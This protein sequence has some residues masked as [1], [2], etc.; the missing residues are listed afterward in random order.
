MDLY[1]T[2]E[3]MR[4]VRYNVLFADMKLTCWFTG[5]YLAKIPACTRQKPSKSAN[6][7]EIVVV[8]IWQTG[9]ID[10]L[11]EQKE[12]ENEE[13]SSNHSE[14]SIDQ[15]ITLKNFK[16][17]SS[18]EEEAI[19]EAMTLT[20]LSLRPFRYLD[21]HFLNPSVNL[22]EAVPSSDAPQSSEEKKQCDPKLEESSQTID[23]TM[24]QLREKY[25]SYGFVKED[26]LPFLLSTEVLEFMGY[27]VDSTYVLFLD[28]KDAQQWKYQSGFLPTT[29]RNPSHLYQ[30]HHHRFSGLEDEMEDGEE[31]EECTPNLSVAYE[32]VLPPLLQ[33]LKEQAIHCFPFEPHP[34]EEGELSAKTM[35]I[36]PLDVLAVDCEMCSTRDG[37]EL[38]RVSLIH[39]IHGIILDT[40]VSDCFNF[41]ARLFLFK[42]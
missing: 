36:F 26:Y 33:K 34:T 24:L 17:N 10:I 16:N 11:Y 21:P 23:T 40:F 27:L 31:I 7:T 39:P 9:V 5:F 8:L 25:T 4:L 42:L 12:K 35:A 2:P 19:E 41:F 22:A 13:A 32:P 38:A 29:A 6:F 3:I 37:L 14:Y 15:F 28:S 18:E 1:C 30:N 20:L